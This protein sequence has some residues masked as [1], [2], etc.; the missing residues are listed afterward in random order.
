MVGWTSLSWRRAPNEV[1][2]TPGGG[3]DAWA[4][5]PW[6]SPIL[7]QLVKNLCQARPPPW[8]RS[9]LQHVPVL[10]RLCLARFVRPHHHS[11]ALPPSSRFGIRSGPRMAR[12][13]SHGRL[14]QIVLGAH[15]RPTF[16]RARCSEL[17]RCC[18][19]PVGFWDGR[20]RQKSRSA[21]LIKGWG[22]GV[23][24]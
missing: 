17:R 18:A 22:F 4:G 1:L 2:G 3:A 14:V 15:F 19:L 16:W 11:F 12:P 10:P 5:W 9:V 8:T 21:P 23:E 20:E 6:R 24:P 13:R 7:D